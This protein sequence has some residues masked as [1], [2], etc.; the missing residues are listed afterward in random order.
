MKTHRT[1]SAS[2]LHNI[3]VG[4]FMRRSIYASK[5]NPAHQPIIQE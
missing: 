5:N 1:L 4:E 2:D 3:E